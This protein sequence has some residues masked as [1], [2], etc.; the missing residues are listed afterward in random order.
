MG[1][2]SLGDWRKKSDGGS[3]QV[4]LSKHID[5]NGC[6]YKYRRSIPKHGIGKGGSYGEG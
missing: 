4:L 5:I 6:Y 3:E 1:C 2:I